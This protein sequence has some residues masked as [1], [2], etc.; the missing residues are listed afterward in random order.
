MEHIVGFSTARSNPVSSILPQASRSYLAERQ[1]SILVDL[2][3]AM[4]GVEPGDY[5]SVCHL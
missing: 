3:L 5:L 2:C 1:H 4:V